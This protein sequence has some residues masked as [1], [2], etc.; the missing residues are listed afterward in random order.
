MFPRLLL[1]VVIQFGLAA[2][3][4]AE[5]FKLTGEAL[6]QAVSGRTVLLETPIGS[7]PIRYRRDGTMT[8]QAP[9]LSQ[10]W[11]PRKTAANGGSPTTAFASAGS[12]GWTRNNTAL[13]CNALV[14]PFIGCAMTAC[15]VRPR[16]A[17]P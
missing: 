5:P 7:F 1:L 4:L 14:P 12:D 6:R 13:S 16:S 2:S 17:R 10:A 3:A 9:A 8:G 15:P 11:E